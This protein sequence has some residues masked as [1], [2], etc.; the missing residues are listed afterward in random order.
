[1][2]IQPLLLRVLLKASR[3]SCSTEFSSYR[4]AAQNSLHSDIQ[5]SFPSAI[6]HPSLAFFLF[7][8]FFIISTSS[9]LV[10]V[11]WLQTL[12]HKRGRVPLSH[13]PSCTCVIAPPLSFELRCASPVSAPLSVILTFAFQWVGAHFGVCVYV[14][15]CS[16]VMESSHLS[17]LCRDGCRY[18]AA[19]L[20]KIQ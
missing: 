13:L 11:M 12:R 19:R 7:Y 16:W 6:L 18:N 3:I 17:P 1:M 15:V 9:D 14:C 10:R 2:G 20:Y 4:Q 8:F 5:T